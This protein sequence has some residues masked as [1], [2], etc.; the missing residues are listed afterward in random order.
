M[1]NWI[2][3]CEYDK[4][5]EESI[6]WLFKILNEEKIPYKQELKENW[7]GYRMPTYH[8]NVIIYVPTEYKEKVE[9]YLKEYNNPNNIV[10]EEPEELR[11]VYNDEDEELK[12]IKKG[13]IAKKMLAWIPI[14]MVLIVIICGIISSVIY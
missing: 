2:N 3:V 14:G 1:G 13:R 4:K 9:S 12:D 11:D 8:E 7:S 5:L 10:Y 6:E